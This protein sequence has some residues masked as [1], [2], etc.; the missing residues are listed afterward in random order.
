MDTDDLPEVKCYVTSFTSCF[1]DVF[2]RLK[3]W[4][5]DYMRGEMFIHVYFTW[6]LVIK[7]KGWS[8]S[9]MLP[10]ERR[11]LYSDLT[12]KIFSTNT[13]T[14]TPLVLYKVTHIWFLTTENG[15][16]LRV[17]LL[18]TYLDPNISGNDQWMK[19]HMEPH[20][21]PLILRTESYG[22]LKMKR[23]EEKFI[24]NQNLKPYWGVFNTFW[25]IDMQTLWEKIIFATQT[26]IF[27]AI[28]LTE[29]NKIHL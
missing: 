24:K 2:P 27:Y 5:S 6:K 3:H 13:C 4:L 25:V 14:V 29:G 8:R 28:V 9:L 12:L 16:N 11:H 1:N 23:S 22:T 26:G 18:E 10:L 15:Y 21:D 17:L 19:L 20:W 7:R